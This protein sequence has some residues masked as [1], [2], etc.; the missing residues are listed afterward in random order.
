L[1]GYFNDYGKL[2]H[3]LWCQDAHFETMEYL[4]KPG[5]II[6]VERARSL[7]VEIFVDVAYCYKAGECDH[8][9][10]P[11]DKYQ[12][13]LRR[14]NIAEIKQL[15]AAMITMKAGGVLGGGFLEAIDSFQRLAIA[16]G[17]NPNPD[18]VQHCHEMHKAMEAMIPVARK[19]EADGIRVTAAYIGGTMLYGV[20]PT[21]DPVTVMLEELGVPMTHMNVNDDRGSIWEWMQLVSD[22]E[23]LKKVMRSADSDLTY[24]VE[25]MYPTDVWLY[26]H[27][28]HDSHMEVDEEDRPEEL[29]DPAWV[30][31]QR[32]VWPIGTTHTYQ[33]ATRILNSLRETFKKA[34]RIAPP[35]TCTPVDVTARARLG[36]GEW[37]CH[38]P[39]A[40]F[41]TC[42]I[43]PPTPPPQSSSPP[44]TTAENL[45]PKKDD[46]GDKL[47]GGAVAGIAIGSAIVGFAFGAI[48][49]ASV[50]A[51]QSKGASSVVSTKIE[52]P[53]GA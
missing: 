15:N 53:D 51:R 27:R 36:G 14:Y 47:E 41:P 19:M 39:K 31:G 5:R 1:V 29:N 13:L 25:G 6:D 22:A 34:Q 48:V 7:N 17:D 3:G 2:C 42:P 9:N 21:D 11:D 33:R 45:S 12:G 38:N 16:V 28:M 26:D 4:Q 30:A 40:T 20:Q 35:S 37:A 46:D 52:K 8:S 24:T 50:K 23:G 32:N 10:G 49:V 44:S 18:V 43:L